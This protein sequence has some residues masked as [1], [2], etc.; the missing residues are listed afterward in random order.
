M[1]DF[2]DKVILQ[3]SKGPVKEVLNIVLKKRIEKLKEWFSEKELNEMIQEDNLS[4]L[5]EDYL[6]KL[7]EK[8][9]FVSNICFPNRKVELNSIYEPLEVTDMSVLNILN[10]GYEHL[11]IVDKAGFGKTT[12][13][14]YLISKV[15]FKNERIPL[16]FELRKLNFNLSFKENLKREF[17]LLNFKFPTEL[18]NLLLARGKFFIV[19]DGFD[20]VPSIHQEQISKE[21]YQ[22]S[23]EISKNKLILTSRPQEVLPEIHLDK[24]I[25]FK[26]FTLEMAKS[27]L[28][29]YDNLLNA[30]VGARLLNELER[31]PK[32]FLESPLM[33]SLLYRS[34][35][36][37][38]SI[39][40]R[41]VTFY[42]EIYQALF[43]GHD[44]LNKGGFLRN[45]ETGL[46]VAEFRILLRS[47]CYI[48]LVKGDVSFPSESAAIIYISDA[49]KLCRK[50]NISAPL[51]LKDL[52]VAVPFLVYDGQ[53]IK[54]VHK[55]IIEYFAAE[56]VAYSSD[57]INILEKMA[58]STNCDRFFVAFD[59]IKQMSPLVHEQALIFNGLKK[60][61]KMVRGF[62]FSTQ[63]SHVYRDMVLSLSVLL[64]GKFGIYENSFFEKSSKPFESKKFGDQ[65]YNLIFNH[66][67]A[68]NLIPTGFKLCINNLN[69][70]DEHYFLIN[71]I[72]AEFAYKYEEM[73][74]N[75]TKE[76]VDI[77]GYEGLNEGVCLKLPNNFKINE[78]NSYETF[79][80]YFNMTEFQQYLVSMAY[81]NM[82][83]QFGKGVTHFIDIENIDS[84]I[85]KIESEVAV[86]GEINAMLQF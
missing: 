15:L 65:T 9:C 84:I 78:L 75:I 56:Y 33:I 28:A 3:G 51:Y 48:M 17:D 19:L 76:T 40:D 1:A 82:N 55:T 2:M 13:S 11:V 43:K 44:L 20:E 46:D 47:L 45:K 57:N 64:R 74:R 53:E 60:I 61:N 71:L 83:M 23:Y 14:K 7:A 42:E 39:A 63:V 38:N 6:T 37:N 77:V 50:D 8:V 32:H 68:K 67:N 30:D 31:I 22:F 69:V 16:F 66:L 49:M 58:S 18:F 5:L 62:N 52:L 12:F 81:E 34:Y 80:T 85:S 25:K 86:E 54:F 27:L 41:V 35:G 36:V 21:I 26:E 73:K 29:R 4:L 72:S 79:G 24:T 10:S 59:F 70:G